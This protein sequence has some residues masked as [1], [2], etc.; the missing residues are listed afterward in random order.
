[1]APLFAPPSDQM[2]RALHTL[3]GSAHMAD[4]KPIAELVASLERF[5]KELKIYQVN[6]DH[7]ILQL[8]KDGVEYIQGV[9]DQIACHEEL[10][11]PR[12]GQYLARVAE[13]KERSVAPLIRQKEAEEEKAK[14]GVDPELLS[15]FM[16]EEM[17]LLLDVDEIIV[18]WREQGFEPAE[19]E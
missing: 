9:L 14:Q 7:D 16:A 6:I 4:V 10:D 15:I 5:V 1:S 8:L 12:L 13:L 2:Q 3:K 18:R 17:K 11:I 19:A